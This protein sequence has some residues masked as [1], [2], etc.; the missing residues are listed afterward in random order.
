MQ[1]SLQELLDADVQAVNVLG[2]Q[3]HLAGEWMLGYRYR[4]IHMERNLDGKKDIG[5]NRVLQ[6][7]RVSPADMTMAMH[8]AEIMYAPTDSPTLMAM[9]LY[10][11]VSWTTTP[12]C[13]HDSLLRRSA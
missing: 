4:S 11:R 9:F 13:A 5:V 8:M 12:G 2:T 3:T 10:L 1:L 6:D 7:F